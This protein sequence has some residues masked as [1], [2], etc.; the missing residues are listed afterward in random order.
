HTLFDHRSARPPAELTFRD[1]WAINWIGN[2]S[3]LVR[4]SMFEDLGGFNEDRSLISVEDYNLWLRIA[5][6]GWKIVTCPHILVHYTQ[7]VGISSNY[8]R[9]MNATLANLDDISRRLALPA[10]MVSSKRM[11]IDKQFGLQALHDRRPASARVLLSR[12]FR[13]QPSIRN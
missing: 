9:L 13:H 12:T 11:E 7:G 8:D 2:S 6:A 1:L 10:D 3:V 4:R 5:A